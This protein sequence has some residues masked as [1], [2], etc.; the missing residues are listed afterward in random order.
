MYQLKLYGLGGQGVVTAARILV[1]A[2]T[3]YDGKYAR[4]LPAYGHERRGAP[5]FAD[6]M[7]DEVQILLSS[8][9]Y[10]PDCVMLFDPSFDDIFL[11]E[12]EMVPKSTVDAIVDSIHQQGGKPN[13]HNI[14][15]RSRVGK[16]PCQGTF[17]G[18]RM[19]AYLFDKGEVGADECLDSLREFARGRWK[20]LYSI[21]WGQQLTQVELLESMECGMLGLELHE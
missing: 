16:G 7:I 12:C 10:D 18:P 13:L 8:F 14:G 15:L 11:C 21:L 17:C 20:G 19:M 4:S 2:C 3:I 6:V 9:V 1:E 5:V